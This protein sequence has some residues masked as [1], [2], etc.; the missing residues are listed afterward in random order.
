MAVSAAD[1]CILNCSAILQIGRAQ[2]VD[3]LANDLHLLMFSVGTKYSK[4]K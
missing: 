4:F 3:P 2:D 1:E